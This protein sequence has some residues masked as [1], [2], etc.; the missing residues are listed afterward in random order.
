MYSGCP[1]YATV[2][3]IFILI[4]FHRFG[5]SDTGNYVQWVSCICHGPPVCVRSY[6]DSLGGFERNDSQR[7]EKTQ[8]R[9]SSLQI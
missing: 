7:I 9:Y 4:F 6:L 1:V 3:L 5:E 8:H 2:L